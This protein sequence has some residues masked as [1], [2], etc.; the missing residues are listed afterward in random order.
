M[1]KRGVPNLCY[2]GLKQKSHGGI[3]GGA[4]GKRMQTLPSTQTNLPKMYNAAKRWIKLS[5]RLS[6]KS[7]GCP[8]SSTRAFWKRLA[9]HLFPHMLLKAVRG[10][11]HR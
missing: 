4:E 6:G 7:G 9:V 11:H 10:K 2:N 5:A 3:N 1:V 8:L